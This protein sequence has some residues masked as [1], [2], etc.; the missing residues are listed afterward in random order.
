MTFRRSANGGT[1]GA[2]TPANQRRPGLPGPG[3]A[4]ARG[5]SLPRQSAHTRR[6][7]ARLWRRARRKQPR[8]SCRHGRQDFAASHRRKSAEHYGGT[9]PRRVARSQREREHPPRRRRYERQSATVAGVAGMAGSGTCSLT[10]CQSTR[11]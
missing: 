10:T 2:D 5:N 3:N 8:N 6:R 4:G 11:L 9:T 1:R 7:I